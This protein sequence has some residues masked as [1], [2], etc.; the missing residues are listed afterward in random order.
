MNSFVKA[1][2][3]SRTHINIILFTEVTLPNNLVIK[4]FKND[5]ELPQPTLIKKTSNGNLY[6]L[7][8]SIDDDFD[9][10][11]RYYVSINDFPLER[12]DVSNATEG[13]LFYESFY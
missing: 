12:V 5:L 10:A 6:F 8:I 2:L 3:V 1:K 11:A 7:D 13:E 4:L 9:F